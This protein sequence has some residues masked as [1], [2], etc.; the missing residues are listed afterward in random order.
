MKSKGWGWIIVLKLNLDIPTD[1]IN[2]FKKSK[3]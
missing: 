2:S 3:L 1:K